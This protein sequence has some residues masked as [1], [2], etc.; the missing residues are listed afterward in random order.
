[1]FLQSLAQLMS[2]LQTLSFDQGG[3]LNFDN[4]PD[5]PEIGSYYSW[6]LVEKLLKLKKQDLLTP[7][8]MDCLQPYSTSKDYFMS[9][10]E[11]LWPRIKDATLDEDHEHNSRHH[12]MEKILTSRP[13]DASI[14]PGDKKKPSSFATT[15][16]TSRTS[17]AI[18]RVG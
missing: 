3:I 2:R 10:L 13:F 5:E 11:R 7:A 15:T 9:A 14:K 4:D 1:M 17:Y 16:S 6:K 8:C 12:I 18:L